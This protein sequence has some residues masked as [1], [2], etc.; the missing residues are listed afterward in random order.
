M[1]HYPI[2]CIRCSHI[3]SNETVLFDTQ[4]AGLKM[5][6][7]LNADRGEA[8]QRD[9]APEAP[10]EAAPTAARSIWD[11]DDDDDFGESAQAGQSVSTLSRFMTLSAIHKFC[12]TN[13]LDPCEPKWQQIY[14]TPDFRTDDPSDLLVGVTFQKEKG[15]SKVYAS[16]RFCPVCGCELPQ[17]S[18]SMPTY[19][20]TVMG[21]SSSGKTV[22]LCALNWLL[23]QS[24]GRL[25]YNANITCVSANKANNDLV[26][27]SRALF[28]QGLL[29]GTTQIVLTEPLTIQMTF[30]SGDQIK[31]CLVAMADMRGED[32]VAQDGENLI[33]K[34]D[35]FSRADGFMLLVSPMNMPYIKSL[36]PESG[37]DAADVNVHQTLMSN[38]NEYI[39]PFFANGVI[40]A[41]CAIMMSKSDILMQNAGR[42]G[43]PLSNAVVAA[44]PQYRYTGTYFQ[45]QDRGTRTIVNCDTPLYHFLKN[46]FSRS[47]FT[48][49]SSL[50]NNVSIGEDERGNQRVQNPHLLHPIRVVDPII[51]LL[52]SLG[53]LPPYY[54]ME[55]GPQ[56]ARANEEILVKW[57]Q[58]HL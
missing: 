2:K 54:Q 28:T 41:P 25:P 7:M 44:E 43:I 30:R 48:S 19:N 32:L 39:L 31:K 11:D 55:A 47:Y 40:G 38:I 17:L 26:N 57:M 16:R 36:L 42:L 1:G 58:E 20:L 8:V 18:G 37:V 14:V 13:Q 50:G 45:N 52:M 29:P 53:F 23:S 12:E 24:E 9:F 35:Y 27:R 34:G 56:Y 21:T 51:Y 22:Y 3:M 10:V 4:D 49:F 15:G 5:T 6:E 46:A 33:M